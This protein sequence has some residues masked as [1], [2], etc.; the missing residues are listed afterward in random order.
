MNCRE[1]INKNQYY[2]PINDGT[3]HNYRLL[4]HQLQKGS[5]LIPL[6]KSVYQILNE[7]ILKPT[8]SPASLNSN[9]NDFKI[10]QKLFEQSNEKLS[11]DLKD[12]SASSIALF[13]PTD[14]A[15]NSSLRRDQIDSL[16]SD[17][18]S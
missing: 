6:S 13:V 2:K 3:D 9:S 7:K 4:I 16:I 1:L 17:K 18:V 8:F 5:L 15:F 12:V 11:K 14:Q 10:F